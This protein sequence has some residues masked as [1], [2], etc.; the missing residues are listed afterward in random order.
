MLQILLSSYCIKIANWDV[1][2]WHNNTDKGAIKHWYLV[3]FV[4]ISIIKVAYLQ[5]PYVVA[6]MQMKND[7]GFRMCAEILPQ[8]E[9][10]ILF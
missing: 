1:I 2:K 9:K 4:Y 8:H 7:N 3:L 6:T 10:G 5:K